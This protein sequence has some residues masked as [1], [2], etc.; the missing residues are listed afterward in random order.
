[1]LKPVD[2]ENQSKL[3]NVSLI[4]SLPIVW[5]MLIV[6]KARIDAYPEPC[7]ISEMERY[8]KQLTAEQL[9]PLIISVKH[10]ILDFWD[11]SKYASEKVAIRLNC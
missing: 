2:T 1:M 5:N 9:K 8:T 3:L 10:S 7:Q 6:C 4:L 11:G